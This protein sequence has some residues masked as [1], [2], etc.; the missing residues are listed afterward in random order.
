[1][2]G[3]YSIESS[4]YR[5]LYENRSLKYRCEY[6]RGCVRL[7]KTKNT[8]ELY[9]QKIGDAG[10]SILCLSVGSRY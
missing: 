5:E 4:E 1:M 10:E 2:Y 3:F 7:K 8:A 6:V 9:I